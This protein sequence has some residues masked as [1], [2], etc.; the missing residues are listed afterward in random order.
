MF[1][2]Y[3]RQEE[4]CISGPLM[5][6][7]TESSSPHLECGD[8]LRVPHRRNLHRSASKGVLGLTPEYG[9]HHQCSQLPVSAWT[10]A[11]MNVMA[12]GDSDSCPG[13]RQKA[14][15]TRM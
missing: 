12:K 2:K 6:I 8:L 5:N 3:Y 15:F 9:L 4:N 10:L 7:D 11:K 13:Y 14:A 1:I